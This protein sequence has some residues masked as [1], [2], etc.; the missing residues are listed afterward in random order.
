MFDVVCVYV[1][2][3]PMSLLLLH[4]ALFS[5]VSR[6]IPVSNQWWHP[7]KHTVTGSSNDTSKQKTGISKASAPP[8]ISCSS[9]SRRRSS[10]ILTSR[11]RH[12]VDGSWIHFSQSISKRSFL[13]LFSQKWIEQ[14]ALY[15]GMLPVRIYEFIDAPTTAYSG[16]SLYLY[17]SC[18]LSTLAHSTI[19]LFM[20]RLLPIYARQREK[21]RE[22]QGML[23]TSMA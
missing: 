6:G 13:F 12:F 7:S 15:H 9:C 5:P 16:Y 8:L 21:E 14:K 20:D 3:S 2:V 23:L 17:F 11:V 22:G 18:I 19:Q 1:W 10:R 4:L